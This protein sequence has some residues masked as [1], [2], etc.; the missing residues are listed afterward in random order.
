MAEDDDATRAHRR[1]AAARW[2]SERQADDGSRRAGDQAQPYDSR[3]AS[4]PRREGGGGWG[5]EPSGHGGQG[6]WS[7]EPSGHGRQG[8]S[9]QDADSWTSAGQPAYPVPGAGSFPADSPAASASGRPDDTTPRVTSKVYGKPRS[10][11]S[12][13]RPLGGRHG[14]PPG[15]D[16]PGSPGGGRG[17]RRPR[18][19]GRTIFRV[20]AGVLA[21]LIVAAVGG[22]FWIGSKLNTEE[23]FTDY[24]GRPA[25][26]PG[27][28]WLLVGSDSRAG[29]SAAQRKKLATGKAVGKRTDTMMLLHIPESG[30]PT[31][32]SLPRDSYVPIEGHG[33]DKLNAAYAFGGPKLLT[34]TVERVTGIRVDHYMEIGFGGFVGIVD[35]VGGVNICVKQDI[36]DKKAGI[37]LKKGCQDMDGGTALGYVR[38]RKTG[39]IPDFDRTQ[40]QRQFFSAIVQKAASPGTLLNPFTSVPLALSA[41][42]SVAVDPSTGLFDLLSVGLAMKGGPVTTA[43][44]I[45]SLPTINGAAVVKWDTAKAKRMFEALAQDK[46]IPK[47][48]LTQ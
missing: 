41:A 26:T 25:E 14:G 22:Y 32:V 8:A 24:S 6:G 9:W 11:Q 35:A 42:D 20:V 1:P 29:L 18:R 43:V 28:D 2:P 36:K 23:A 5:A 39:A 38:T 4:D 44:P 33:S 27:E 12:P 17:A 19:T 34:K 10:G 7:A 31:L 3:P 47:D 48:T 40:R 45:G 16:G 46:P 37:N 15:D 13:V 21:V 30:R